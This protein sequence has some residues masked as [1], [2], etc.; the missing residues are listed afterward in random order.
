MNIKMNLANGDKKARIEIVECNETG[1][2]KAI[3]SIFN[4]FGLKGPVKQPRAAQETRH[5]NPQPEKVTIDING[6]SIPAI[7][8]EIRD[9]YQEKLKVAKEKGEPDYYHTGI[10]I[11]EGRP[12]YKAHYACPNCGDRSRHY[13]SIDAPTANCHKCH[14][15][16]DFEPVKHFPYPDA[17]LNFFKNI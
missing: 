4:F 15:P 3:S 9:W 2:E 12:T 1:L 6:D 16:I 14:A 10:K 11:K 13:I 17:Y 7:P 8:D 5:D